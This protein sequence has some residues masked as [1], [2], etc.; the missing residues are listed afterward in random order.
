MNDR[1]SVLS[2]G[3]LAK[4]IRNQ[5]DRQNGYFGIPSELFFIPR[6]DDPIRMSRFS[7]VI[8]TPV[9]V[10]AGPHTQL[11]QNIIAAWLC[12]ARYIELKTVQ[13]LDELNVT[14]PC[15]DMQD[16]GYNCEW[17]QELKLEES[18]DQYLNAWILIHILYHRLTGRTAPGAGTIFNMSAGYD[19]KGITGERVTAFFDRMNS[20]SKELKRKSEELASVF[21]DF[22]FGTIPAQISDNITLSTMHGCPAGEIESICEYLLKERKLHTTLKLNPT[23]L[24]PEGLRELLKAS[25]YPVKVPDEAFEHDLK[26][27][28][29]V[30][31]LQRLRKLAD[32]LGLHFGIKLTNTLESINPA[33]NLPDSEAFAYMSGKPLHPIAIA[34]AEKLQ[35]EFDGTLDISFSAGVNAGNI[36]DVIACGLTPATVCSDLLKPGSYGLLHQ[37]IG[38]L[39][40]SFRE[41]GAESVEAYILKKAGT[42][43]L[44]K[45]RLTALER[46]AALTREQ[47]EYRKNSGLVPDIK[48]TRELTVFDCIAAPCADTCPA[49]QEV[50]EYMEAVAAENPEEALRIIRRTNSMPETTG[51]VCDQTCRQKCTRINYDTPL[52]IREIKKFAASVAQTD[53]Q[54]EEQAPKPDKKKVVIIGAGP[55]GISC[56][57]Q[58][59]KHGVKV[60][61]Y[62][63]HDKP[64]G[65]VI[66]AIPSF[67][68]PEKA[69]TRDAQTLLENVEVHYRQSVTPELFGKLYREADALYLAGGAT[70]Y[71]Q[72]GIDGSTHPAVVNAIDFLEKVKKGATVG[73]FKEIVVVGG[74][75][76]AMDAARTAKR[77]FGP[78]ATVTILYRRRIEDM[79]AARDEIEEG[80]AEGIRIVPMAVPVKI[81]SLD[82]TRL[83]GVESIRTRPGEA[84]AGGRPKPVSVPGSEFHTPCDLLLTAIGT[85]SDFSWTGREIRV[86]KEVAFATNDP[87]IFTGGDQLRGPSTL[88]R[89][90]ADGQNAARLILKQL[91]IQ[92]SG[93]V[94]T[95]QAGKADV[96][97]LMIRRMKRIPQKLDVEQEGHYHADRLSLTEPADVLSVNHAKEEAARCLRCDLLCNQCVV[98]CP[99]LALYSYETVTGRFPSGKIITGG[100]DAGIHFRDQFEIGQ[101]RQILHL[102]GWCNECGNCRTF[103]PTSGSPYRVKPHLYFDWQEF[104][105]EKDGYFYDTENH[106]LSG[107]YSSV[108]FD[109]YRKNNGYFLDCSHFS[110]KINPEDHSLYDLNLKGNNGFEFPVEEIWKAI[111]VMQGAESFYMVDVIMW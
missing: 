93:E 67:R 48:T 11:T 40:K 65:R 101:S 76:T 46:Y 97:E 86:S 51:W 4:V 23:L 100:S 42:G 34:L 89:A 54:Q 105:D 44:Q 92:T 82:S 107:F 38:N 109:L 37:Y 81:I 69:I 27:E 110:L 9:G 57:A 62:E 29:A 77:V 52:A 6:N 36:A 104:N 16:E 61:L 2:I 88:I 19:L 26:Y 96:R 103:C 74:G 41:A 78:D 20:S 21:P 75:N 5:L 24:G 43:N 18:Y 83:S 15:I 72:L 59:K 108:R 90:I 71:R 56:A 106:R 70:R 25:G 66:S 87:K 91:G 31:M 50:P 8:D 7:R 60:E 84:D 64:G 99:N 102:A 28:D 49:H 12:G 79:P 73:G 98:V 3:S 45:A 95:H 32:S 1:F 58:L 47:P 85:D 111:S 30:P 17:S 14:K 53:Y 33:R 22:D 35:N 80:L 39:R 68:I 63:Q 94:S 55:S 13:V 10:A